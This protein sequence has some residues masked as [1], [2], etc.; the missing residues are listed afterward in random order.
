MC[1]VGDILLLL[2]NIALITCI[3]LVPFTTLDVYYNV[4]CHQYNFSKTVSSFCLFKGD[5]I[6]SSV[7]SVV[8]VTE[9]PSPAEMAPF[10]ASIVKLSTEIPVHFDSTTGREESGQSLEMYTNMII[11]V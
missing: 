5:D 11:N 1:F 2:F 7:D 3:N 10:V 6:A 9:P 8:A 4:H